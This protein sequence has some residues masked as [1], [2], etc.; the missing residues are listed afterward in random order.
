MEKVRIVFT[1][2]VFGLQHHHMSHFHTLNMHRI[3]QHSLFDQA[4]DEVIGGISPTDLFIYFVHP[5]GADSL[6]TDIPGRAFLPE[7]IIIRNNSR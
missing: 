3:H 5:D 2:R 4:V 7:K 1:E 6:L